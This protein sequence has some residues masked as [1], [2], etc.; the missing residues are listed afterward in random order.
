MS[1]GGLSRKPIENN[2][3]NFFFLGGGGGRE[4]GGV[5]Q[6]PDRNLNKLDKTWLGL[7]SDLTLQKQNFSLT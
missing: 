1:I 7:C 4:G 6:K 2:V 3:F 5:V